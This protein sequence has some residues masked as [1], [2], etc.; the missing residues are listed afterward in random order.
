MITNL[1]IKIK[2]LFIRHLHFIYSV[3]YIL[4]VFVYT[5]L[6]SVLVFCVHDTLFYLILAHSP[7]E[8]KC[9]LT[10]SNL[11]RPIRFLLDIVGGV[12][13]GMPYLKL[14]EELSMYNHKVIYIQ[15]VS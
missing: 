7:V 4:R 14:G 10:A 2:L 8:M 15:R 11:F 6:F 3:C 9:D 12:E 13:R 5:M 1:M